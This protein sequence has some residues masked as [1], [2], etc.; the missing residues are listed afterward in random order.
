ENGQRRRGMAKLRIPNTK[1]QVHHFTAARIGLYLG[2]AAPLFIESIERAFHDGVI[3]AIPYRDSLL[4]VYAG[5]FLIILFTCL[6]G[7]NMYTWTRS[8]INYKFIFEFDPRDN[9]NFLQYL[10]VYIYITIR[11]IT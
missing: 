7:I 1:N 3:D 4:L 6:F 2:L 11:K 5:L 8:R 10:E 9:L